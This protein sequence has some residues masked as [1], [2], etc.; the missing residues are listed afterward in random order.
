ML[1]NNGDYLTLVLKITPRDFNKEF[2]DFFLV[3]NSDPANSSTN[4]FNIDGVFS[5]KI[6]GK[7]NNGIDYSCNCGELEG[8]FN[9]HVLCTKCNSKVEFKGLNL[10]REGWVDLIFPVIHPLLYRYL[11]KI[12]SKPVL[13]RIFT[14]KAKVDKN[15]KV[16]EPEY[17][18]PYDGIGAVKFFENFDDII[19]EFV[20]KKKNKVLNDYKFILKYKHL[21]LIDKF[22]IIN[23]KLR[24]ALMINSDL[25]YHEINN[26]YNG[27]IKNSNILKELTAIEETELNVNGL[28][29][30]NQELVNNIFES[31][32]TELSN[33]TGYIRN[34]MCGNRTNFSSRLVISPLS[35]EFSMDEIVLPYVAG[36]ELLKP[37]I[38]RKIKLLKKVN[39]Y[40][41]SQ[42]W[43]DGLLK[44]DKFLH[45]IMSDIIKSDNVR[46]L[47]NRNPTLS[48]IF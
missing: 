26:H 30:K 14:Y 44:F 11:K 48:H 4:T 23:S 6:F 12:T 10:A 43:S 24:P 16:I 15:G 9:L 29:N 2:N 34:N 36:M 3:T 40:K 7:L 46:I 32:I 19:L 27:L 18:Y 35:G 28:I 33:K 47:L 17:V 31:I 8:E 1:S 38:I 22:P 13:D 41:A 20:N 42:I 37:V 45:K 5:E 25:E 39:T 21:L